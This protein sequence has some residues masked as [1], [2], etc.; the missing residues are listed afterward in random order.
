[1]DIRTY[2]KIL[3]PLACGLLVLFSFGFDAFNTDFSSA[4]MFAIFGLLVVE[5]LL[6]AFNSHSL[7]WNRIKWLIL[8]LIVL[9]TL[10]G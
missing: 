4:V 8:T 1:M 10:I 6:F 7:W 9:L 5:A 2:N 3:F